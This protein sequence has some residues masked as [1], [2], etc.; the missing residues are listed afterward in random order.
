MVHSVALSKGLGSGRAAIGTTPLGRGLDAPGGASGDVEVVARGAEVRS[1]VLPWKSRACARLPACHE[2]TLCGRGRTLY[3]TGIAENAR[4][5][6]AP[7]PPIPILPIRMHVHVHVAPNLVAARTALDGL[8][9]GSPSAST[10]MVT[11]ALHNGVEEQIRADVPDLEVR[12]GR[13]MHM[14]RAGVQLEL[15]DCSEGTEGALG[16]AQ[17]GGHEQQ[18]RFVGA[19]LSELREVLASARHA[20]VICN[21]AASCQWIER[22]LRDRPFECGPR[23]CPVD[24]PTVLCFHDSM[25]PK[26]RQ[27]ALAAFRKRSPNQWEARNTDEPP[28]R[29]LVATGRAVRGLDLDAGAPQTCKHANLQTC[30]HA[31]LQT[32]ARC[33]TYLSSILLSGSRR[34]LHVQSTSPL[35]APDWRRVRNVWSGL[36]HPWPCPRSHACALPVP[37]R[38]VVAGMACPLDEVV[39]F[40]FAPDPKA[41]LARVGCATRGTQPASRVTALVGRRQLAF[42]KAM[43]AHDASGTPHDLVGRV[44]PARSAASSQAVQDV[45]AY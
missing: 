17:P 7:S 31:N 29:V 18:Q 3:S 34:P 4:T 43:L 21:N 12:V 23:S 11:S 39:L 30:K 41:Y 28:R 16:G 38:A 37:F 25:T 24:P 2:H 10:I 33:H 9:P 19:K 45:E 22:E 35:H 40:D 5:L 6:R 27:A 44:V 13:G 1:L 42:A 32:C 36:P 15:I 14:T 20:L 8:P 26:R